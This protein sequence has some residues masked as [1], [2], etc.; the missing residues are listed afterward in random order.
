MVSLKS[1]V[2]FLSSCLKISSRSLSFCLSTLLSVVAQSALCATIEVSLDGS[3][4]PSAAITD[5]ADTNLSFLTNEEGRIQYTGGSC[6]SLNYVSEENIIYRA[7]RTCGLDD[8]NVPVYKINLAKLVTLSG[9]VEVS[10]SCNCNLNFVNLDEGSSYGRGTSLLN[11]TKFEFNEMLPAG[12]Y[13]IKVSTVNWPSA[14]DRHY[15]ASIGVDARLHSVS[16]IK[17]ETASTVD[18]SRFSKSPPRADLISVR[19]SETSHLSFI[20]GA[21]G[22]AEAVVPIG[23]LNLQTG[24]TLSGVS[25]ADGSFLIKFFA[26]PGSAIQISQ[27]RHADAYN[28]FTSSAPSTV[29][30]VPQVDSDF[31]IA[32]GQRLNGSSQNEM[33]GLRLKG[34]KDPGVAWLTGTLDTPEWQPGRSGELTGTVD[35]YSRNLDYG[36]VPQLESGNAYLEL[37]FNEDGEQKTSG[38][39]NSSSDLTVTGMPIER[40]EPV[41]QE[42]IQL[43]DFYFSDYELVGNG[44]ARALWTLNYEVPSNTPNGVYQLVLSGRGWS[45]NPWFSG[46][47]SDRLFY[48]D[49]YGEPSFHLTNI[50]GAAR[51]N[52]GQT[53][54]LRL[55]SAILMNEIS[56][57]SRGVVAKS[58]VSKFG[59]SSR[60]TYN[61]E[62]LILPPSTNADG[63]IY[64]YNIEPFIQLTAYSNKE[65]LNPPKI[66]LSF[67]T[68]Q[69]SAKVQSPGGSVVE[70]GPHPIR[71]GFAQKATTSI[72]EDLVRNSNAP[73][74]H[75]AL[76]TY[77]DEFNL[78]L[79]EYGE[80]KIELTGSVEDIYGE[81]YEISGNYSVY[82]AELL[83]IETGVFPGTPFE[84]GDSFSSSLIIQPGLPAE[85][86]VSLSHFPNSSISEQVTRT[87]SGDANRF[88]YFASS[89]D[90]FKFQAAGEYLVNY[91]VS[92]NSPE[93]VLWMASRKWASVVETPD[94]NIVAHGHR[95][96]E[97][98]FESRQWYLLE[99]TSSN[100]NGHF[101]SPYQIGDVMWTKNFTSWNAAIQNIVTL[102]DGDG[103]LTALVK[104][105]GL[106]DLGIGSMFLRSSTSTSYQGIPPF[107]DPTQLDIH[108]GYYYSSIGRPGVSVREFVGT[109][110]STNGYWRFNTSYG[111]QLGSGYEGDQ[112]NDFKF[113]FGGA[114]YRV[115]SENFSHYGAYGSLWTMLPETDLNGGRVMPPFQG[116]SGGPS[117]GPLFTLNGE[118]IDIFL[119]PQGVRPGSILEVGDIFSF[120]GQI[121][122]TL[123]SKVEVQI[124]SPSGVVRSFGGTANKVGYFYQPNNDY[125][126]TEAGVHTVSVSVV[127]EGGTSAGIVEAPYPS[128]SVL[129]SSNGEFN[130]YVASKG[131][132]QAGIVDGLPDRL[133]NSASVELS[134][135]LSNNSSPTNFQHTVVMPGFILSQ[136]E[137]SGTSF[138]YDAYTLNSS[139][140]NL[141]LPGGQLQRRN[142][143]DTV[144][145]SFLAQTEGEDGSPVFAG[146]QVLLQGEQILAPSH[147]K[148][149]QGTFAVRLEENVL[150]PGGRLKATVDMEAKGDAD[151]YVAIVLPSGDFITFNKVLAISGINQIIPF[152]E[153]LVLEEQESLSILDVVLD[154]SVTAGDYRMVVVT[155]AAGKSI[156]DQSYWLGF[157]EIT[158]SFA[159]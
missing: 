85:V 106:E 91:D 148:K 147:R 34:G 75:Y 121:G 93:G 50:H 68:G 13:R 139:F 98:G 76:T 38:P 128:G 56:N 117:G 71:G 11:S 123:P 113:I 64:K 142:G 5:Y 9:T 66:P 159:N 135:Q 26:P 140:P 21:P 89:L 54:P 31:A 45:M 120:S 63:S 141:D 42:S 27:D 155:T 12:R 122:P 33:N 109:A 4:L 7:L 22:A 20:E 108:W 78:V 74:S 125:V 146:R 132:Q 151:I 3:V 149:I 53:K 17:I 36:V 30:Y 32:T 29:I 145:L 41:Y 59:M 62:K 39:Q 73:D 115:P 153:Y 111:Y 102:E 55:Y 158:F 144:T 126:V 46:L 69:L 134:L 2:N 79:D 104:D 8:S 49:V 44:H 82:V 18:V 65:W 154:D 90:P 124:T 118:E 23:V 83:D 156:Y 157:D 81:V 28:D 87:Y 61:A 60:W 88:G 37:L 96:D 52:I 77:S 43:G 40:S 100:R 103:T 137:S 112:P 105:R 127:H 114:V 6:A 119:H 70:I 131:A 24:Q 143:A 95:G 47:T 10:Q 48:E 92:Y 130:F 136:N 35:I 80:Y 1:I 25:E 107:V 51:I 72:G 150:Q 14:P 84:V 129:G 97:A 86:I 58:D 94:T 152:A 110:Q 116:A 16:D 15:L 67:P 19:H 57:G 101:F 138:K 99:D 133:S